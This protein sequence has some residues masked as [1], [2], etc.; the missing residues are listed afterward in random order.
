MVIVAGLVGVLGVEM[1]LT[2]PERGLESLGRRTQVVPLEHLLEVE[3]RVPTSTDRAGQDSPAVEQDAAG[4]FPI[5]AFSA[6]RS[7]TYAVVAPPNVVTM[8][9]PSIVIGASIN[10]S[11]HRRRA[12]T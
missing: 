6:C 5:L 10:G 11:R 4:H 2:D 12:T 1:C 7:I 9:K 8:S 3:A